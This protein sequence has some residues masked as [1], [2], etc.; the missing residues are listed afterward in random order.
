MTDGSVERLR[1][2]PRRAGIRCRITRPTAALIDK[3]VH[4]GFCLPSCPTYLL[5]GEEMDSPRG[6]IYLMNAGLDGRDRDDSAVRAATS[7]PASAAWR[8]S[9]R[10]RLACSTRRSSRRR[11]AQIERSIRS[12]ARRSLVPTAAL[13]DVSVS[14]TPA[15]G[16]AAARAV[17]AASIAPRREAS[18]GSRRRSSDRGAELSTRVVSR[19]ARRCRSRRRSRCRRC[20]RAV[21]E[22]TP[23]R[24]R[25]ASDR[26]PADRLRPARR[27]SA[28]ERRDGQ[29]AGGRRLRRRRAARRRAAAA[30]WRCM[31]DASRRRARSRG[32]RSTSSSAP[33]S[34]AIAVNAAGCG[35]SMKEYGQLLADDPAWAERARAFSARVRDVTELL[36]E[37]G[38]PR[39]TRHPMAATVAYH[40]ACHL[41]HAQGVR[42]QPRDLL[43]SIPGVE[44]VAVRR[45]GHLLRQRRHLQ[46]GR[47]GRGAARSAI[48][49][50]RTSPPSRPTS[51]PPPIP[52]CTLQIAAAARRRGG[53]L[54]DSTPD[55]TARRVDS[56]A[57]RGWRSQPADPPP[58]ALRN[59]KRRAS[60]S[61]RHDSACRRATT[62]LGARRSA[63]T[64]QLEQPKKHR[65]GQHHPHDWHS[66]CC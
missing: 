23:A 64:T 43:R 27:L 53:E 35:S 6:R 57:G 25:A 24:R 12:I 36:A 50:S 9:R 66:D 14:R 37:L 59:R 13:R 8:A 62:F 28:S 20:S 22:R 39:A 16:A 33:A 46:P 34:S 40:D 55:R 31:P 1:T 61:S 15:A 48:A 2:S 45:A 65:R 49:R 42:Q 47:A 5:W 30:R 29:R 10:A 17:A 18:A 56:R 32:G 51:S 21:P 54:I 3:C 7:T 63:R 58:S 11:A 52:G 38:E 44:L 60:L 4:C 41:A 19:I 26:R